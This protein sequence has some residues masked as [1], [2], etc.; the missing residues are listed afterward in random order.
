MPGSYIDD[1]QNAFLARYWEA[2]VFS[3][4]RFLKDWPCDAL[5]LFRAGEK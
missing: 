4:S 5:L 3:P 2:H 1:E